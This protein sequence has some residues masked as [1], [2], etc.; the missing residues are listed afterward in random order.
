MGEG[1]MS[2]DNSQD[3]VP[4]KHRA[5]Q[6]EALKHVATEAEIATNAVNAVTESIREQP[7]NKV[8]DYATLGAAAILKYAEASAM[9]VEQ[10]GDEVMSDAEQLRNECRNLAEDIRHVARVQAA[11]VERAMSRN[12]IAAQGI[13]ELRKQFHADIDKE[14]T[15][16]E[17]AKQRAA[18]ATG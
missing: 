2:S 10:V 16:L 9:T 14:R 6:T 17:A 5:A 7:P 11:A 4:P 15:E 3:Y 13:T 8:T 1:V 12:K 18:T